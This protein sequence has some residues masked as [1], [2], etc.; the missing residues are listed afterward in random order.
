MFR[1]GLMAL[2]GGLLAGCGAVRRGAGSMMADSA[3]DLAQ[4]LQRQDDLQLVK[5]GAPA[6]LLL[7]DGLAESSENPKVLLAASSAQIAYASAFFDKAEAD[8][9][10]KMYAKA[11]DYGRKVLCRNKAFQKAQSA[12][13][14]EFT[15]VLSTFRKEDVPALYLTANAWTGWILNSPGDVEALA[16]FP[17]PVALMQRVLELDPE[18]QHGGADLFFG[19]YYAAQPRGAGRN[20]EKSRAHF[21]KAIA[22]A[23]PDILLPRVLF[24]EFY[25]RYAFD[26]ALFDQTLHEVLSS[27][28]GGAPDFRLMNEAARLR[29]RHLLEK[30]DEFF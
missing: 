12:P 26:A 2:A 22:L 17:R 30:K 4:S 15:A 1:V 24:A 29:A 5:D 20:L 10:R 3:T 7:L 25:A 6:Y 21:E 19:I 18:Y 14:D 16:Q 8:R 27:S 28:E 23:G 9:A 13:V 11:R